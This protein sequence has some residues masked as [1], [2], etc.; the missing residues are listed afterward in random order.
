MKVQWIGAGALAAVSLLAVGLS[1]VSAPGSPV[2]AQSP[3]K[4]SAPAKQEGPA[5]EPLWSKQC[6]KSPDGSKEACFVQQFLYAMPQKAILL[7]AVFGFLGPD[8]KPRLI[9][10]APLG[11]LLQAGLVLSIDN[12]KPL[13]V[14]LEGC[15]SSG[16]RAVIDMDL[17]SLDQF[18]MGKQMTVRYLTEERKTV[19]LPVKLEGLSAALKEITPHAP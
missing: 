9:L 11:I 4:A 17:P 14:P 6:V 18:R 15:Q 7:K 10:T 3:S 13:T 19:D 5:D 16:C 8:G 2:L 1:V 12:G